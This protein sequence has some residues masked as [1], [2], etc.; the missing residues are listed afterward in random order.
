[1]YKNCLVCK[2]EFR[3][4]KCRSKKAKYC[5]KACQYSHQMKYKANKTACAECKVEI[6]VSL[7][8]VKRRN[9]NFCSRRCGGEYNGR[10]RKFSG[11]NNPSW[12]GGITPKHRAIRTSST[13]KKW[14]ESI[15]ERD[16]YTCVLCG[17]RGGELNADHIKELSRYPELILNLDNGRTLCVG[18]HRK[19]DNYGFR[20]VI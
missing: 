13:Y 19:T 2:R 12:K 1:M 11:E 7:S 3:I 17:I 20:A 15:F 14:R 4:P 9:N 18:C 5:S 10:L 16:D 8:H 6:I